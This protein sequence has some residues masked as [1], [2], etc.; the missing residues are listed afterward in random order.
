MDWMSCIC[1][2]TSALHLVSGPPRAPQRYRNRFLATGHLMPRPHSSPNAAPSITY[3]ESEVSPP[4]TRSGLNDLDLVYTGVGAL[5][6]LP[7]IRRWARIVAS[8]LRPGGRLFM[9]RR[10]SNAVVN[11]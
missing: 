9:P 3:V 7:D 11:G 10:T 4:S 8:L 2:A 1:S 6:W 5:C